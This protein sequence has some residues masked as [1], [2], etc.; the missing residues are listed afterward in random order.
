MRFR[1]S[2]RLLVENFKS[3]YKLLAYKVIINLVAIALCCTFILPN[4]AALLES[5]PMQALLL[6]CDRFFKAILS[7][8]SE[9]L[10]AAKDAILKEDGSLRAVLWMISTHTTRLVLICVG[11]G[12]VLFLKRFVETLGYF[13][14][15]CLLDD[16][17]KTYSDTPFISAYIANLK[18]ASEYSI[19]YASLAFVLDIVL[20]GISILLL[21][22]LPFVAAMFFAVTI[23]VMAQ[24][25]KLTLIG[26]WMPS[27]TAGNKSMDEA[28][29]GDNAMEKQL[30]FKI[31]ATYVAVVYIV[32]MLNVVA[33]FGTFGSALFLTIPASY[34]LLIAMQYVNYYTLRGKKYFITYE[35]IATNEDYGDTEHF[36]DH[37]VNNEQA[38]KAET[39]EV[40]MDYRKNYQ[41]WLNDERLCEEGKQELIAIANDEKDIE[42]RFGG[43]MEFGTA[44]MRGVIGYGINMM[45]IYTVM[46]ATQGL[47]EWIKSLGKEEMERGVVISYDTRRKS[48]EF[49]K[50]TAGVLAKNGIKAYLFDDV[51]PVPM[52]SYAVRYLQTIAGVMIT[53][54]HNPKEY[55]GYKVYGQDGA[56]MSPEDTA[57]V[58]EYI[59]KIEDYLSV[60]ADTNSPLITAVPKQLDADYIE[61][62]SKLTLSKEAVEK[63]GADLKLVYTPVHGSGYV[64]VT[65]ILKKLGINATIV[66]EQTTKDTEFSTVKVPNPEYK[67]TLSMG[68][69]L[70]NKINADV[71]FG[72][73]PDSDRLG[74]ALKDEKGEFVALSGNQVGI[75]LLDYI[76]TRLSEDGKMPANAAVV[77][78]FVTTG[79]AKALCDDYGVTLYETPV[80]FK[81]IGEKI[82][83]WEKDNKHTYIFGFEESCGYL[84][85]IHARDKDAVVASM[86]CAE[87]VCY[88]TYIGKTV[89]GRLQEIYA[90]YGYVLDKNVSVQYSGLNAMKEMNAVVDGLKTLPV[91]DFAGVKVEA[92]RDYS[93]AKRK[94]VA[95]G[96]VEEMEIPKCNCVYYELEGGS[97]VC[98]RPSGTEPKLKIYY[99]LKAKDEASANAKLAEMQTSVNDLLERAKNN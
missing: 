98:V 71:V 42:Y 47:A 93:A 70:A 87:M 40:E 85:G 97:F 26:K 82:K 76:L 55:N 14:T 39:T 6:D 95:T 54:S 90:K 91:T 63:C 80:G 3:V 68:I 58:V 69:A 77:K 44:G 64:P 75:L 92:V 4:L 61:E 31:F 11:C 46:R 56:Q 88:Y 25:L 18:K 29:C 59:N 86:L 5:T 37:L 43:E 60:S 21:A 34:V 22:I 51:H 72:T 48:E 24:A 45:N 28:M 41:N 19:V 15:G 96:E 49:A 65:A 53:A 50:V 57:K 74:V 36:F 7:L 79:M 66:E 38:N 23:I 35:R 8:N 32:M 62:L 17:M 52:L 9:A 12:L 33:I 2:I 10:L 16:K 67:E 73:D 27:I 78:S 30:R 20:M 83:Q 99:S 81:F 1:N 89:Y 94:I 13:T 84:R